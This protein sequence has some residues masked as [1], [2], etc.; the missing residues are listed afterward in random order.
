LGA[1]MSTIP[2]FAIVKYVVPK[3]PLV[4]LFVPVPS[5]NGVKLITSEVL[6]LK[7]LPAAA[8]PTHSPIARGVPV[9]AAFAHSVRTML[10]V[11]AL[12]C[13]SKVLLQFGHTRVKFPKSIS[14]G[15]GTLALE[16]PLGVNVSVALWPDE[17]SN[18]RHGGVPHG[19]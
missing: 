9:H 10:K 5:C 12:K 8:V 3:L 14:V 16:G 15:G 18:V 11:N 7:T 6:L 4:A 2:L 17:L 13:A 19:L 1:T